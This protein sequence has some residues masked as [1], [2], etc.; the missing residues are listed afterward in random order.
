[1]T[2]S[3]GRRGEKGGGYQGKRVVREAGTRML[4]IHYL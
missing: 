3:M 1:M 4:R 2:E